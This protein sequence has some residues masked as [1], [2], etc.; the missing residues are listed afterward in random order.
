MG[1]CAV[2]RRWKHLAFVSTSRDHKQEWLRVADTATGEVR[3]VMTE[4]VATFFRERQRQGELEGAA[5]IE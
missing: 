2:E 3:D 4:K 1:R 5:G